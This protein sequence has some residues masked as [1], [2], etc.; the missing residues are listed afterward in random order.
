MAAL[1]VE[2]LRWDFIHDL[3]LR[4]RISYLLLLGGGGYGFDVQLGVAEQWK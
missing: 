2:K 4:I 1:T 3:W